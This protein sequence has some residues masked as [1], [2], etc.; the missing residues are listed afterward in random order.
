MICQKC[1]EPIFGSISDHKCGKGR[2]RECLM[3]GLP[4]G[5]ACADWRDCG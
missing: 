4:G 5:Q 2:V 1:G 3:C